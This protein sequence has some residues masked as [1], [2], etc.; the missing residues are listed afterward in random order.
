MTD[1]DKEWI[2]IKIQEVRQSYALF[3]DVV[4]SW[5]LPKFLAIINDQAREIRRLKTE[6]LKK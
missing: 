1:T 6:T 4:N 5:D 2:G 3:G